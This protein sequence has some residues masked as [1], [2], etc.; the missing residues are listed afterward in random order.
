[1]H[2]YYDRKEFSIIERWVAWIE[3]RVIIYYMVPVQQ[4]MVKAC[5][6]LRDACC[7]QMSPAITFHFTLST[8]NP[9]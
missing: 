2:P 5:L 9:P 6:K 3:K 8:P 7:F 4:R 1:M